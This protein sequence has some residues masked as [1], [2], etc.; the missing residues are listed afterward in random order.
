[1]RR[2]WLTFRDGHQI[3]Y[4]L[5]LLPMISLWKSIAFSTMP[6]LIGPYGRGSKMRCAPGGQRI[7]NPLTTV[8]YAAGGPIVTVGGDGMITYL[9]PP[10]SRLQRKQLLEWEVQ[11]VESLARMTIPLTQAPRHGSKDGYVR[12]R[13][14]LGFR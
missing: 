11:T 3:G 10:D 2:F 8:T 9:S 13:E 6:L 7:Q 14:Q 4:T 12:V 1:M 5:Y